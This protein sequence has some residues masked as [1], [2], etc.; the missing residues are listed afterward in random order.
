MDNTAENEYS[1]LISD[2]KDENF[3]ELNI[4]DEDYEVLKLQKLIEK[5]GKP[6]IPAKRLNYWSISLIYQLQDLIL[7]SAKIIVCDQLCNVDPR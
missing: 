2:L 7:F 4:I 3:D 5:L 6:K 1:D